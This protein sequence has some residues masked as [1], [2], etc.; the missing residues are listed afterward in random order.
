MKTQ[1]E[2][3]RDRF[4]IE[5]YTQGHPFLLAQQFVARLLFHATTGFPR[6]IFQMPISFE[7]FLWSCQADQHLAWPVVIKQTE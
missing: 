7:E 1:R 5:A 3:L 2:A 6:G 4:K